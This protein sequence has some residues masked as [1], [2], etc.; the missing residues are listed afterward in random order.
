[1]KMKIITFIVGRTPA[2][3]EEEENISRKRRGR[4]ENP[5]RY[6]SRK[7]RRKKTR[8]FATNTGKFSSPKQ[9]TTDRRRNQRRIRAEAMCSW[10]CEQRRVSRVYQEKKK[11]TLRIED[12]HTNEKKKCLPTWRIFILFLLSI[13]WLAKNNTTKKVTKTRS[14][15][16]LRKCYLYCLSITSNHVG[17]LIAR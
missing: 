1:M 10:V 8:R 3:L 9:K 7:K 16:L 4:T 17:N 6:G 12:D 2:G 15:L 11:N 14:L 13:C 5:K